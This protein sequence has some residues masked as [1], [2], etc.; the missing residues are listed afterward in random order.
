MFFEPKIVK[1]KLKEVVENETDIRHEKY[2]NNLRLFLEE[3]LLKTYGIRHYI[4]LYRDYGYI[5]LFT[6]HQYKN[7]DYTNAWCRFKIDAAKK[8]RII[9]LK[10]G[11]NIW[12]PLLNE[13]T[14]MDSITKY[15][16]NKTSKPLGYSKE[17]C[18]ESIGITLNKDYYITKFADFKPCLDE[19]MD[20]KQR[21]VL[22]Q[23]KRSEE[24][25][26]S[27]FSMDVK[28][29]CSEYRTQ[30]RALEKALKNYKNKI[31]TSALKKAQIEDDFGGND[32]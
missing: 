16:K 17:D 18:L 24:F 11:G 22:P 6:D 8:D 4:S 7:L 2:C 25:Y 3:M 10:E 19:L 12:R 13:S 14:L 1:M 29:K 15:C 23:I 26:E 31:I 27:L 5:H 30:I 9:V 32:V 21:M 28:T 20:I